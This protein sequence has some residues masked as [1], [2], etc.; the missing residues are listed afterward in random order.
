MSVCPVFKIVFSKKFAVF[1]KDFSCQA[2]FRVF[3]L[4]ECRQS[5]ENTASNT[6]KE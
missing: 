3:Q 6:N 5:P 1:G 4:F 2:A